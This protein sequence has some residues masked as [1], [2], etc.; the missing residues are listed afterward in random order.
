MVINT[1]ELTQ[2]ED[3]WL[4]NNRSLWKKYGI[5]DWHIGDGMSDI[6]LIGED[7]VRKVV[8][9]ENKSR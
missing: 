2:K 9:V 3:D 7:F 8:I 4:W 6:Q 5:K 1:V